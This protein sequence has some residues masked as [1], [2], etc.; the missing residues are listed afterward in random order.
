MYIFFFFFPKQ[1]VLAQRIDKEM[2]S[3]DGQDIWYWLYTL[4]TTYNS[5]TPR[6][7]PLLISDSIQFPQRSPQ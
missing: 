2:R 7:P 1:N 3:W 5:V 6:T 4:C